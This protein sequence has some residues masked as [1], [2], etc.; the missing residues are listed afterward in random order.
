MVDMFLSDDFPPRIALLAVFKQMID[1][2]MAEA[3]TLRDDMTANQIRLLIILGEPMP[4]KELAH[5]MA[6]KPSNLTPLVAACAE[7]GWVVR[8]QSKSDKRSISAALTESGQ[9]ERMR[10]MKLISDVVQYVTGIT[11]AR[12][13]QILKIVQDGSGSD[14]PSVSPIEASSVIRRRWR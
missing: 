2:V 10:L 13:E 12:A 3:A 7:K 4:M 1:E 6:M 8:Q 14:A 5:L 11:E 9:A